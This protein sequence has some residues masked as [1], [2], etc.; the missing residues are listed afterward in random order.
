MVTTLIII[1]I[2]KSRSVLRKKLLFSMKI[3]GKYWLFCYS[4]NFININIKI[5]CVP[6]LVMIIKSFFFL[7]AFFWQFFSITFCKK[8]IKSITSTKILSNFTGIVHSSY[9]IYQ[10]FQYFQLLFSIK[11]NTKTIYWSSVVQSLV[12]KG[13]YNIKSFHCWWSLSMARYCFCFKDSTICMYP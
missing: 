12:F 5:Y 6:A 9:K 13:P 1:I 11:L 3:K 2:I 7:T 8:M 10:V 4:L